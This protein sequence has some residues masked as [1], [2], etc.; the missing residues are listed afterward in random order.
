M[1]IIIKKYKIHCLKQNSKKI[2]NSYN[3][4]RWFCIFNNIILIGL[5]Y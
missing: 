5:V 4:S 3:V 1:H 2:P